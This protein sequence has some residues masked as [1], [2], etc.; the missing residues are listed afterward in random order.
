[1][2][3]YTAILRASTG[4]YN[5]RTYGPIMA[6]KSPSSGRNV[7]FHCWAEGWAEV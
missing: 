5:L 4:E 2:I 1:M 7:L 3:L 6:G